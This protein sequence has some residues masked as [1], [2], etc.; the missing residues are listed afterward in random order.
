MALRSVV[1]TFMITPWNKNRDG[2]GR[3]RSSASILRVVLKGKWEVVGLLWG[4]EW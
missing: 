2:I 4:R 3:N 1:D